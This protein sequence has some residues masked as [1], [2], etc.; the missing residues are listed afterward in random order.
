IAVTP[1][2]Y[3]FGLVSSLECPPISGS[4]A[5]GKSPDTNQGPIPPGKVQACHTANTRNEMPHEAIDDSGAGVA[6]MS[7]ALTRPTAPPPNR[8]HAE[9]L[10]QKRKATGGCNLAYWLVYFAYSSGSLRRLSPR[11]FC[12]SGFWT[13]H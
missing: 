11:R 9:N 3:R 5:T 1:N 12:G 4:T 10:A 2:R 6:R 7:G 13:G 8:R